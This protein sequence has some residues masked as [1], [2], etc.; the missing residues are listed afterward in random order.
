MGLAAWLLDHDT[1][2]YYKIA[3]VFLDDEPVA[4]SPGTTS[5]QTRMTVTSV[6][7]QM[8]LNTRNAES[9]RCSREGATYGRSWPAGPWGACQ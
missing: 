9:A 2:A 3:R 4:T 1:G 7:V 6:A 8:S 5:W